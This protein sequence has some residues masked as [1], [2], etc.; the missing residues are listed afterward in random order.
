MTVPLMEYQ[1]LLG[2]VSA[3]IGFVAFIP[4]FRDALLKK[5]K[6]HMFSWLVWS[7]IM[8]ATFF[9]SLSKGAGSGAWVLAASTAMEIAILAIALFWWGEKEIVP[10]DTLCL[11]LALIGIAL[12]LITN[13]PLNEVVIATLV[14]AIA[15]VPTF[16]KAYKRPY[17]ETAS[18][19]ALSGTSLA[20]S[21]FALQ[22]V[23]LT[24]AL[25]PASLVLTNSLF[26]AVVLAR[27]Q[28]FL[29]IKSR[30]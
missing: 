6:P 20:I 28:H 27:R 4:Y 25:Y 15:F 22:S 10:L 5:T 2:S 29:K 11:V 23:T 7:L 21:L 30:K 17:E 16:R 19:Y 3:V 24:T 18:T 14:D 13:K 1:T 9:A 12:W 26:V 8:G